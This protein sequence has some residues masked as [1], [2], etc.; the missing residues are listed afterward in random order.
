ME[1]TTKS[2]DNGTI[3]ELVFDGRIDIASKETVRDALK[4]AVDTA[5]TIVVVDLQHVPL[6]DSSGL[7]ALVSGL[8]MAREQQKDIVLAGLNKH[9][10]RVF[11]LTM[12]DRVGTVYPSIRDA[13]DA[14][15][16]HGAGV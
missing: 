4:N 3:V 5:K 6:I 16:Q 7:S 1:I 13:L 11:S 9:A 2:L 10:Q 12:M 8:R 15:R 14:H